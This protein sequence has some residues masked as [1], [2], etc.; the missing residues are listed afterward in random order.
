MHNHAS[1]RIQRR[2]AA[3]FTLVEVLIC[4]TLIA[5]AFT[6]LTM[7]FGQDSRAA[8]LSDQIT[9]ASFLADEV[10][11]AALQMTFANVLAL[12][13]TTL[14]PAQ[15]S[16][17]VN[18]SPTWWT[19]TIVVTPVDEADLNRVVGVGSAKACR[20]TVAVKARGSPIVT[21]TYYMMDQSAV[22]YTTRGG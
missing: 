2:R 7:A 16:T 6:A 5:V 8:Q 19:Q 3:A 22:P 10:R 4:C 9:T 18:Y 20:I 13:G 11:D 1:V 21:Q 17:G 12:N 14:N 15:L